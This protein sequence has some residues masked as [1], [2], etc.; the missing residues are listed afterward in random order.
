MRVWSDNLKVII[1]SRESSFLVNLTQ[2][3]YFIFSMCLLF[4]SRSKYFSFEFFV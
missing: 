1:D 4:L 3:I 2:F